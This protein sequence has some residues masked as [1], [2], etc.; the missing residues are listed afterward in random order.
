[1]KTS[2]TLLTTV[3][4]TAA[5]WAQS[6]E[7]MSY[8][9]VIRNNSN[10]LVSNAT[11]GMKISILQ[12]SSE[13]T[14]VYVETQLPETNANGLVSIE[15]GTG[16]TSDDFSV[17]DW[18]SGPY[19]IKTETDLQGGT[20]YSILGTSQLLSVP[21]SLH[22]KTAGNV[23]S[24]D[25]S[26][27]TNT[28]TTLDGYGILDGMNT[29]HVANGITSGLIAN[30]NVA[31]GWGDH[32]GLYR[33]IG[34]VPAWNEITGRPTFA[35]VATSGSYTDLTNTPTI[36]GGQWTTSG[37][38]IYY[39][40]GN[41][42]IGTSSPATYIHAHGSPI[43]SRG[44]LSLSAP[45]GEGIFL[46]MY[47]ADIFKAYLWYDVS[48]EDL[49]LQNYTAGDLNL[50]PYGGNVGIGTDDPSATLEVAGQVRIT[51]GTPAE[52]EVLTSDG[53][54]LATWEPPASPSED[55]IYFEVKRDVSYTWGVVGGNTIDFST[56][57]TVLENQGD[58]FNAST[59]RF[60]APEN[61]IYTFDGVILYTG[62]TPGTEVSAYLLAGNRNY[63]GAVI[64]TYGTPQ[65]VSISLTLYLA[66][67]QTAELW[68]FTIDPNVIVYGISQSNYAFTYFTG[69]KVR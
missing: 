46:S 44:Q 41:V 9:A 68:G 38:D 67:G 66:A 34:Y 13:G 24:G 22:S 35:T 1:M 63:R 25:Y 20:N 31:F 56:G 39:N 59:S 57:S 48:A 37:T 3:L 42:G 14:V 19:F 12:G 36:L 52:G 27:L 60:T 33:P 23:F 16:T 49:R 55:H 8:Q 40:D 6:P 62:L 21:Y 50:N 45:S 15:I 17:I 18:S 10:D 5:I 28:P 26:D 65:G 32:D 4:L 51:G 54:G 43:P 69:A 11:V 7:K 61:G 53:T 2:I 64:Q 58:A 29:S 47:D 30:W